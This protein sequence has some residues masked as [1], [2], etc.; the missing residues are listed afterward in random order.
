MFGVVLSD[1]AE[2]TLVKPR[3]NEAQRTYQIRKLVEWRM[4]SA[5]REGARQYTVGFSNSFPIRG[6]ISAL[7]SERFIPETL[8]RPQ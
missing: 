1:K 6:A 5:F 7:S 3:M 8:N 2:V 4:L